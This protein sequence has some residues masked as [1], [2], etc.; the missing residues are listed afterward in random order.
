MIPEQ[1]PQV[2]TNE[3]S[4]AQATAE[5]LSWI[6]LKLVQPCNLNCTYCYVYNRGNDSWK[7]RPALISD[8]VVRALSLR[9]GEQY[10]KYNLKKF[11]VEL[12]GGEPLL[13]GKARMQAVLDGFRRHSPN[14]NYSFVMQT[15]GLLLDQE[16]LELFDRNGIIFGISL[17][18]P[19][20]V[21]DKYRVHH[22]GS[23]STRQL[24]ARIAELR[25][26]SALFDRL[27]HGALCVIHPQADGAHFVRWFVE[28]GFR[29]FDFL[30]PDGTYLNLPPGWAGP[31][32]YRRFLL[33]A[34]NEWYRMGKDA[35]EIRTFELMM[36]GLM[37]ARPAV[38]SLGGDLTLLCVVESDGSIGVN[39]TMRI[40]GEPFSTDT[41]NVFD[42]PLDAHAAHYAVDKIQRPCEQ[43]QRCPYFKAC[44][45]G[46]LPH[47]FDGQSFSN[48]SIYCTALYGLAGRMMECLKAELPSSVWNQK[49]T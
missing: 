41:L 32:P 1:L 37:G 21:A 28:H 6:V 48:P 36:M 10:Q 47:R 42:H 11:V 25:R 49:G 34:F 19:P 39:D 14:V 26:E 7:S 31:D 8:D 2:A 33:E 18:G 38:D 5:P 44:G 15:N 40:C 45:G 20:E 27:N 3:K 23:G 17:D 35:P 13:I 9:I 16:W 24:L 12:H 43:C 4:P 22:D 29:V 30:L 46:Y